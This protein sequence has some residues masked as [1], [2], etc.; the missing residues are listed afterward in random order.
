MSRKCIANPLSIWGWWKFSD[1]VKV[2]LPADELRVACCYSIGYQLGHA[3]IRYAS[4]DVLNSKRNVDISIFNNS[5]GIQNTLGETLKR[6]GF[7]NYFHVFRINILTN[8]VG[9]DPSVLVGWCVSSNFSLHWLTISLSRIPSRLQ[10]RKGSTWGIFSGEQV[11]VCPGTSFDNKTNSSIRGTPN[12]LCI[13]V[14][15]MLHNNWAFQIFG[16]PI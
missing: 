15:W 11:V 12:C 8:P 6:S 10:Q 4:L 5:S 3:R 16:K 2:R 9:T 13:L 1:L 14:D 7:M